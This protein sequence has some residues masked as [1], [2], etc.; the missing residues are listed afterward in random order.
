MHRRFL[1]LGLLLGLAACGTTEASL[2]YSPATPPVAQPGAASVVVMGTV[3]DERE[4]GREDPRWIGTVRGGFGNPIKRLDAPEP[5]SEVVRKAFAD[6]LRARGL[7]AAGTSSRFRLDVRILDLQAN[8]LA[9]REGVASFRISLVNA[10]GRT[11]LSDQAEARRMTG[12][13][14]SAA[15]VFGSVDELQM[16]AQQAM[17]EAIDKL[18]DRPAFA[19]ALR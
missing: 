8:Q 11:V 17:S 19:A 12:S 3:V 4:D 10:A 6:A 7:L 2:P 14:F 15:G 16:V 13:F 9:R 18:L 5:V 1:A